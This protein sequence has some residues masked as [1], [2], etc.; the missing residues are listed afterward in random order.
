[1]AK[2]TALTKTSQSLMTIRDLL[3]ARKKQ[4][5]M[6][7]PK[8]MDPDRLLRISM[9]SIQ[10]N[11]SLLE[12]DP[13]TLLS[14]IIQCAQLGLEPDD[15]MGKAYLVPFK[16]NK[17]GTTDVQ[18]IIGYRGLIDLAMRSGSVEAIQA[19]IVYENEPF[20]FVDGVSIKHRPL[21]PS[22]RG[23]KLGVYAVARLKSGTI[24]Y[25]FLWAEEV[26]AVKK[27]SKSYSSKSSPWHTHEEEMWKKTAI[28]RLAKYLPLSVEFQKAAIVDE[29]QE[30]GIDTREFFFDEE[31][32]ETAGEEVKEKTS[33]KVSALKQKLKE[34]KEK[35][36]ENEAEENTGDENETTAE[37]SEPSENNSD[38]ALEA[39]IQAIQNMLAKLDIKK[40]VD[41]VRWV[42]ANT[43]F[44]IERLE[45]LTR[46]QAAEVIE[47]L[48][49]KVNGQLL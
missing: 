46:T 29:Y 25:E 7:L 30:A 10:R 43:E 3:L 14:V 27:Q 15:V 49:K 48:N 5:A 39:Q 11:P 28:R 34:A 4:I 45:D 47:V 6:A 31:V 26:E 36:E 18:L 24:L 37:Q 23:G 33:R 9:T 41:M 1:M 22:K 44:N 32:V 16:N 20:E 17:K 12:C 21:P 42:N 35:T 13:R 19:R 2:V 8:H 40:G 38:P